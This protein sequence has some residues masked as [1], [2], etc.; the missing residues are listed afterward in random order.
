MGCDIHLYGE[1]LLKP[2]WFWQKSKWVT[3]DKWSKPDEDDLW[4]EADKQHK[5]VR[6][7]DRI[8]TDGRNYNLFCAL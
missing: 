4:D 8:Y 2:K 5:E 3:I 7:E 1:K 6:R